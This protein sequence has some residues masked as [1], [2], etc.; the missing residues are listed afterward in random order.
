[1]RNPSKIRYFIA[2]IHLSET[3]PDITSNFT[4]FLQELPDQCELYILGDLFDFWIG[5]DSQSALHSEV[6]NQ[7]KSLSLRGIDVFF[8]PGN[9]DFLLDTPYAKSCNMNILPDF[10]TLNH[11]QHRIL[12]L[13]GDLLCSY[14]KSYQR[15]RKIMRSSLLKSLF[16]FVPFFLRKKIANYIRTRSTNQNSK[17]AEY[18]MDISQETVEQLLLKYN[19]DILI[20]GHTHKPGQYHF[21]LNGKEV[22][23]M[24]L[25]AWHD[26]GDYVVAADSIKLLAQ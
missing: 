11:N 15:F 3:M 1:M 22:E 4:R 13:H 20:Q 24:V 6:A 21:K 19:V 7:I 5:N 26:R 23:R 25:G 17:K 18:K 10:Y 9:R 14:D 16:V 8:T 2:D 12:I